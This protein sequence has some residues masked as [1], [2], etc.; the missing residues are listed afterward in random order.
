MF[1]DLRARIE[2]IFRAV[3][4]DED[5]FNRFAET[6]GLGIH[7]RH[8]RVYPSAIGQSHTTR[9]IQQLSGTRA[10]RVHGR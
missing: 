7:L 4:G 8:G 3:R 1:D 9:L 5:A 6:E 2:D 10:G